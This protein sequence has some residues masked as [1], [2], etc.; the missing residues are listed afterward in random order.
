M[1][2]ITRFRGTHYFL[3]NFYP[4][5]VVHNGI[6]YPS[7]EHAYQ[8]SKTTNRK[9]KEHIKRAESPGEAKRRGKSVPLRGDWENVKIDVMRQILREKF[10]NP[11]LKDLL[12]ATGESYIEEANTWGDTFWG[13][14]DGVG[15]NHLG[16]L[17]MQARTRR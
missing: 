12:R 7:A 9:Y 10:S 3:S 5:K 11:G 15:H 6:E 1:N 13:T 16:K 14:Y 2:K 17:L 4:C 8:A